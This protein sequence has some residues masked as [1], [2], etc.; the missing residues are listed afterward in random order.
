MS[1]DRELTAADEGRYRPYLGW[2]ADVT[3]DADQ[4]PR[5]TNRRRH[6][7]NL[8]TDKREAEKRFTD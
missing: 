8:G 7:F 5:Y 3:F 4:T 2:K 1:R 6:R